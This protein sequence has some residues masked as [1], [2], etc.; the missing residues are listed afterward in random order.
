MI[1]ATILPDRCPP[2][3]TSV[4]TVDFLTSYP[5]VLVWRIGERWGTTWSSRWVTNH[6]TDWTPITAE[7]KYRCISSLIPCP[8]IPSAWGWGW[9]GGGD[10][11]LRRKHMCTTSVSLVF[12]IISFTWLVK[13][14]QYSHVGSNIWGYLFQWE[15][16]PCVVCVLC[17][18][19]VVD[20]NINRFSAFFS[21]H[22]Q[23]Q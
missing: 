18:R 4:I 11:E 3:S 19:A 1:S 6:Y 22:R 23:P 16:T 5:I 12:Q 20:G 2:I 7:C 8:F 14:L 9:G 21:T 13:M 15:N 17:W 10:I